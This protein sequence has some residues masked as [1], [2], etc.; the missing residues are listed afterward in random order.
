MTPDTDEY[1]K[2]R[3]KKGNTLDGF[4]HGISSMLPRATFQFNLLTSTDIRHNFDCHSLVT[5]AVLNDIFSMQVTLCL[6]GFS[7]LYLV[8]G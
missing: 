2:R 4:L 5:I 8:I 3:S 1:L 6:E 7:L